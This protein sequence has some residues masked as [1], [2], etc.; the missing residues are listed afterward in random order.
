MSITFVC[1][2]CPKTLKVPDRAAGRRGR[3]PGCGAVNVVPG[4]AAAPPEPEPEPEHDPDPA[5]GRRD[6]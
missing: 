6:R 1:A 2:A 4:P 5:T 3:C